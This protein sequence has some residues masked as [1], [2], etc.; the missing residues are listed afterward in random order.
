MKPAQVTISQLRHAIREAADALYFL[1]ETRGDDVNWSKVEDLA[2]RLA[3]LADTLESQ[4]KKEGAP[5]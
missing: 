2:L 4:A 1:W 5:A 3:D